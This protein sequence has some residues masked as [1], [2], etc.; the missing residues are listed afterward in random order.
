MPF[1]NDEDEILRV[2]H[3]ERKELNMI[4][5]FDLV[6]ISNVPG[7]PRMTLHPWKPKDLRDIVTRWQRVMYDRGGWNSVFISNQ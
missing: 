1:V 3:E 7:A 6:S 4:F 5:I 2:V